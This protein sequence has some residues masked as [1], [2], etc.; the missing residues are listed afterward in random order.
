MD[1]QPVELGRTL[2]QRREAKG[3]SLADLART[4]KIKESSLRDLEEGKYETL[5]ALVFVKGFVVAYA[6]QVGLDPKPLVKELESVLL[7]GGTAVEELVHRTA[8]KPAP[9]VDNGPR[10]NVALVVFLFVL[11]A[12]LTLSILMRAPGPGAT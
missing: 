1:A 3:M 6:K 8:E 10:L 5:P 9:P 11:V 7:P 2:R 12:T 4:T